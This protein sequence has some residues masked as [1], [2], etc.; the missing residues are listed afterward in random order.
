M[1]ENIP[2]ALEPVLAAV[3]TIAADLQSD[4][5]FHY[6]GENRWHCDVNVGDEAVQHTIFLLDSDDPLLA[7]YVMIRLPA[8]MEH[9]DLLVKAV[10][11]A[12]NGLLPGCFEIDLESGEIHYRSALSPVTG[13]ITPMEVA[14]LLG[15]ALM[16]SKTYAPAFQKVAATGAD[17]IQA[18]DEIEND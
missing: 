17:P 2:A 12:N 11:Y 9:I 15:G 13:H 7:V 8:G 18:I 4:G 10:V 6:N 16:M 5:E 3:R 1:S 14:H